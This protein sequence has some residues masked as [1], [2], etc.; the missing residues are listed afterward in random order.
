MKQARL[1]QPA[2]YLYFDSKESL[3]G[4]LVDLF[5]EELFDHLHA[6]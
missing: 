2:F 4:E 5:R 1:S 6:K 3:F